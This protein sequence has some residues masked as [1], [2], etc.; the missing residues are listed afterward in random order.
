LRSA[1]AARDPLLVSLDVEPVPIEDELVDPPVPELM[2]D[3]DEL[4]VDVPEPV[5]PLPDVVEPPF[6]S[7]AWPIAP[8]F[9]PLALA[10][11]RDPAIVLPAVPVL[12]SMLDELVVP[13]LLPVFDDE[14]EPLV[15][16]WAVASP[17]PNARATAAATVHMRGCLIMMSVL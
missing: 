6:A 14:V 3:D 4:P 13:A 5:V 10:R 1:R 12:E 2:P 16:V 7:V 8:V 11:L 9:E 17:A 15:L